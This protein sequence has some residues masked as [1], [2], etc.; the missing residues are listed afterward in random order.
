MRSHGFL[1]GLAA[2]A[3]AAATTAL[4][5][6]RDVGMETPEEVAAEIASLPTEA[7]TPAV[8]SGHPYLPARFADFDDALLAS[9][10][11]YH[12]DFQ[13]EV[14]RW[15]ERWSR[16]FSR[17][18]PEYLSRMTGFERMVDSTLANR[19]LPPSLRYLPVIESGYSPSAVSSAKRR[20][21]GGNP[22]SAWRRSRATGD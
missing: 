18:M 10:M 4:T 5:R 20:L 16:N 8:A 2:I 17:W 21:G 11:L 1:L 7:P 6:A 12:P 3:A 9:P 22:P 15:V 13:A 19:G 14:D